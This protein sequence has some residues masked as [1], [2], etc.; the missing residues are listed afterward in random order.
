ML[1]GFERLF[2]SQSSSVERLLF[3]Y[4]RLFRFK[5]LPFEAPLGM[6]DVVHQDFPLVLVYNY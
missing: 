3:P 5:P 6:L 1:P 4:P 2:P